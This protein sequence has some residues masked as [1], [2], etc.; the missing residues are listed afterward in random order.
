MREGRGDW[1]EEHRHFFK[2]HVSKYAIS[3]TTH[4]GSAPKL[5]ITP[6]SPVQ[7]DVDID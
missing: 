3:G 2:Q 4:F 5:F 6:D 1:R 7:A